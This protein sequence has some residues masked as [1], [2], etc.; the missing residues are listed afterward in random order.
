MTHLNRDSG[1][2]TRVRCILRDKI[3]EIRSLQILANVSSLQL[4]KMIY[5]VYRETK[6]ESETL[7][8]TYLIR[9]FEKDER[10]RG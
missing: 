7:H 1:L 10:R 8:L 4:F 3:L 9:R 5:A 6:G 2:H